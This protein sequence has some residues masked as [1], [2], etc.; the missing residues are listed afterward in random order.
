[1]KKVLSAGMRCTAP[2][3][4][5]RTALAVRPGT[6][7]RRTMPSITPIVVRLSSARQFS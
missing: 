5:R 6:P 4:S 7:N 3:P 2:I 1:M